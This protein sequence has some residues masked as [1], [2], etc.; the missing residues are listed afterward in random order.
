MKNIPARRVAARLEDGP[1]FF[2]RIFQAQRLQRLA[3][4]R[5]MMAEIVD[6]RHAARDAAHFHPPP[7]ALE[8][9]EGRL[10]LLVLQPAMLGAGDHRQ[11]VAGV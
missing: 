2:A 9:V 6:H 5:W 10:D 7:D 3:D 8:R 11:R 4:G 1:D